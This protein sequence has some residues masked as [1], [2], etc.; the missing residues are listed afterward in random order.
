MASKFVEYKPNGLAHVGCK[1]KAENNRRTHRS[2]LDIWSSL[3]Q[4]PI[5]NAMKDLSNLATEGLCCSL[6]LAVGTSNIHSD[7]EIMASDY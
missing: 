4:G 6:E 2:A 1:N 5:D 7:N 3:P